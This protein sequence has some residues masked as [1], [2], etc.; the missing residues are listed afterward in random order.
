MLFTYFS[1]FSQYLPLSAVVY[2]HPILYLINS[3]SF[4]SFPGCESLAS[5]QLVYRIKEVEHGAGIATFVSGLN[6]GA[7][8]KEVIL[9]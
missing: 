8:G 9:V 3:L 7:G 5:E 2:F 4:D 1:I 6:D